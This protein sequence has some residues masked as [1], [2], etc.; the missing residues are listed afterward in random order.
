MYESFQIIEFCGTIVR[1]LIGENNSTQDAP[2][3]ND[4]NQ[5]HDMDLVYK[6]L[7]WKRSI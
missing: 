4:E 5:S 3:F 7:D 6:Y 1:G 2:R